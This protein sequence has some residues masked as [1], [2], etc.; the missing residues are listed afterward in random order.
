MALSMY[1]E[2]R[3]KTNLLC[4]L[5]MPVSALWMQVSIQDRPACMDSPFCHWSQNLI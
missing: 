2:E 4:Y 5:Q 1:T 3:K